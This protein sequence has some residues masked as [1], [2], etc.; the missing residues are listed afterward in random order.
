M[1]TAQK[2]I[3]QRAADIAGAIW[4]DSNGT[5]AER[6]QACIDSPNLGTDG[7]LT[8]DDREQLRALLAECQTA[9]QRKIRISMD[10]T[11]AGDGD[12]LPNNRI[13]NCGAQF[14]DD[15]DVSVDVYD[16]IEDA[17]DDG[18]SEITVELDGQQHTISWEIAEVQS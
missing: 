16:D 10:G 5:T 8:D 7:D 1:T 4:D 2:T 17:I 9:P 18:K 6:L 15:N 12:L 14:C 13:Q 3:E 11:W